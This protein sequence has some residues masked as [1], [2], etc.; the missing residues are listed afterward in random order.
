[1]KEVGGAGGGGG[2]EAYSDKLCLLSLLCAVDLFQNT[3]F[4]GECI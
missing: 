4:I 1:M 3:F 2:V